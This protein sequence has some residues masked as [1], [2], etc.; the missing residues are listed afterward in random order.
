M[1]DNSA[2][3]QK[4]NAMCLKSV[5]YPGV[6]LWHLLKAV[7]ANSDKFSSQEICNDF[8]SDLR[9]IADATVDRLPDVLLEMLLRKYTNSET[10]AMNWFSREWG[11]D[12]HNFSLPM[13]LGLRVNSY[14]EDVNGQFKRECTDRT[15]CASDKFIAQLSAWLY[16]LAG[17][18]Q[19]EN[20]GL[21]ESGNREVTQ[22]DVDGVFAEYACLCNNGAD[23]PKFANYTFDELAELAESCRHLCPITGAERTCHGRR[24]PMQL[25]ILLEERKMLSFDGARNETGHTEGA[26][27]IC[28]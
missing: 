27:A 1:N 9:Q 16:R 24:L 17:P 7:Q 13:P 14:A 22:K 2:A 12:M 11:G 8:V 23:D 18:H 6:C 3:I 21:S 5:E 4:A 15:V 20:V 25:R 26:P 10:Q 28:Q 19:Q